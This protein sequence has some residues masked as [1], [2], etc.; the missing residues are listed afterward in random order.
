MGDL[1]PTVIFLGLYVSPTSIIG[2]PDHITYGQYSTCDLILLAQIF[3]YRWKWSHIP[4]S[5]EQPLLTRSSQEIPPTTR[6]LILQYT[7]A[8]LFVFAVGVGAWLVGE[9]T[10]LRESPTQTKEPQWAVQAL[11]W[12]SAILYVRLHSHASFA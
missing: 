8:L 3:Y 7:A 6:Q 9:T 5:E 12:A 1:L 2:A 4:S 10:E 11:G